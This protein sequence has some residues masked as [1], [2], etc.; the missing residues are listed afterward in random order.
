M[1]QVIVLA[2]KSPRRKE[3]LGSLGLKFKVIPADIK[4][5]LGRVFLVE[6]LRKV[7]L[8][9]VE[10]VA[11]RFKEGIV[12]GADT[13]VVVNKKIYGKP[14]NF[15]SAKEMLKELSGKA[16]DVW[17]AVAIKDIK[18]I[19]ILVKTARS[20]IKMKKLNDSEIEHLANKNLDKAGAY[21]IQEWIG[22]VAVS[23][24]EGSYANVIGLPVDKVYQYFSNLA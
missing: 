18:E 11:K 9:K 19:K 12:I 10:K 24:I 2:S 6:K 1:K 7:A 17:T 14:K 21:G 23:K 3:L 5:N 8:D 4:E 15:N 20:K 13:I 22:F 16:Q